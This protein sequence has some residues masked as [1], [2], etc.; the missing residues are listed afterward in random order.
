MEARRGCCA[1]RTEPLIFCPMHKVIAVLHTNAMT[2]P[3][4]CGDFTMWCLL[5]LCCIGQWSW[6]RGKKARQ[7]GYTSEG[8]FHTAC[9]MDCGG[10]PARPSP[11]GCKFPMATRPS[12]TDHRPRRNH[13]D[14]SHGWQ[15][16]Q[17]LRLRDVFTQLSTFP[18]EFWTLLDFTS[19]VSADLR[20]HR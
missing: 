1:M 19:K 9:S 8:S 16:R 7:A 5:S 15:E 20:K 4:F 17:S 10:Q 18:R 14:V 13:N 11:G 6:T 3:S 2:A 12:S